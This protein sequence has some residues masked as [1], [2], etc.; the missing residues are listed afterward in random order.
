MEWKLLAPV[1][2]ISFGAFFMLVGSIGLIRLPDFYS[3]THATSKSDTLGVMLVVFGLILYE[4]FTVNSA[5]LL[6][7]LVF[8]ALT[9]P[10]A[11]HALG[12]AAFLFRLKPL[13]GKKKPEKSAKEK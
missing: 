8:V 5:K 7:I 11:A 6:I 4:G 13:L 9:N 12:R 10:T 1:I 3:R 2:F